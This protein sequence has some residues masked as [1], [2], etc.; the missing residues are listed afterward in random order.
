MIGKSDYDLAWTRAESD[1]SIA[2]DRSVMDARQ[3]KLH[4]IESLH[5]AGEKMIWLDTSKVPLIDAGGRVWGVLGIFEDI[6]ARKQVEKNLLEALDRAEAANR[7]KGEFLAVID[8]E[9]RIP[10][11]GVLGFAELLSYTALN[12]EQMEFLQTIQGSGRHLLQVVNDILDFSSI[13]KKGVELEGQVY[14]PAPVRGRILV[15]EDDHVS[16]ILTGKILASLGYEC[17]FVTDGRQAVDA[18]GPGKYPVVLLDMQMPVMDELDA[19]RG[20]RA[21]EKRVRAPA[22]PYHRA[23]G[24]CAARRPRTLHR[25][26]HGRLCFEAGQQERPRRRGNAGR[27]GLILCRAG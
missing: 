7:A 13:E 11:N 12:A 14:P 22:R 27:G 5:E 6:T 10:L 25:G 9:L 18:F 23:H 8:H 1:A 16:A 26:R 21:I 15:A 3:P 17:D 20:I 24:Q 4:I 2:D 19:A